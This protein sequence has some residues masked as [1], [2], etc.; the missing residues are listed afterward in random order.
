MLNATLFPS[1]SGLPLYSVRTPPLSARG[2]RLCTLWCQSRCTEV[3]RRVELGFFRSGS[4]VNRCGCGNAVAGGCGHCWTLGGDVHTGAGAHSGWLSSKLTGCFEDVGGTPGRLGVARS[5][6]AG[7]FLLPTF[8]ACDF[9]L[10]RGRIRQTPRRIP[11]HYGAAHCR[12][13]EYKRNRHRES[14]Q[15]TGLVTAGIT[16]Q[17]FR[18]L[19]YSRADASL[20]S[21]PR[22]AKENKIFF[23]FC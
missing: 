19:F 13:R 5:S 4:A 11:Q 3:K 18:D 23:S 20:L 12:Q 8:I 1:Y 2:R 17:L 10:S 7:C 21:A 16:H 22:Y 6:A 14:P 9:L 15:G